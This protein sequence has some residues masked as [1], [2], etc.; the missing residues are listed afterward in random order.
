MECKQGVWHHTM[1]IGHKG[2]GGVRTE[3]EVLKETALRRS[4]Q[5]GRLYGDE[6]WPGR[7]VQKLGRKS[8]PGRPRKQQNGS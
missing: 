2:I 7:T 6:T 5:R 1:V 4:V 8:P 3:F